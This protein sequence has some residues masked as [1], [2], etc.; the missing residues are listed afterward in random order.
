MPPSS[1]MHASVQSSTAP[2]LACPDC[3]LLLHCARS[4]RDLH[5]PRCKARV[6]D[7]D[8]H[9]DPYLASALA[10]LILYP[11]A[12][13]LPIMQIEIAG[14]RASNTLLGGAL[15]LW[16][17]GHIP[18]AALIILSSV[19]AP[20]LQLL[21]TL[22]IALAVKLRRLPEYFPTL[23]KLNQHSQHWSML[24]VYVIG[25]LVAYV[26]MMSEGDIAVGAGAWCL[27]G[28][29]LSLILGKINFHAQWLWQHW[30]RYRPQEV[31]R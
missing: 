22:H 30:D 23:L 4:D 11:A 15:A 27:G 7:A 19:L 24:E 25:V 13:L 9:I 12:L 28:L 2:L 18:L 16:Q 6:R 3:D 20:L 5:C 1:P 17:Q 14:Q 29:L 8:G 21:L 10:G 31:N 26:K